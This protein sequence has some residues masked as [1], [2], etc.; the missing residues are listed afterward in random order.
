MAGSWK[1]LI[2]PCFEVGVN[3]SASG[4]QN[5]AIG[6]KMLEVE[7]FSIAFRDVNSNLN[8]IKHSITW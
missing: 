8:Y 7:F 6:S 4:W 1:I 5:G 3:L 2:R